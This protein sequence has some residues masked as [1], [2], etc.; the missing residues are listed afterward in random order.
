MKLWEIHNMNYGP[1]RRKL[2]L[3]YIITNRGLAINR[4]GYFQ[5]FDPDLK[6]LLK[7]GKIKRYRPKGPAKLGQKRTNDRTTYLVVA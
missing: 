1:N 3:A 4:K 2:L 7:K 6:H 5:D